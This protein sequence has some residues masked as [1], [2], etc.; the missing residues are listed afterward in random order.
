MAGVQDRCCLIDSINR[1]YCEGAPPDYGVDILDFSDFYDII[2][3]KLAGVSGD[4]MR[5]IVA[6]TKEAGWIAIHC[7]DKLWEELRY[8]DDAS[9]LSLRAKK[10]LQILHS[11]GWSMVHPDWEDNIIVLL[12]H[13]SKVKKPRYWELVDDPR[14]LHIG[15]QTAGLFTRLREG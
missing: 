14:A 9:K 13:P 3:M 7:E 12:R 6:A 1:Y 4:E 8:V 5:Q 10:L 15:N 2:A 11:S